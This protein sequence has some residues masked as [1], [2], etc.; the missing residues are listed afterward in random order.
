M[1]AVR[2]N[3]EN[4]MFIRTERL[5]LRPGW[6]EDLDELLELLSDDSVSRTMGASAVP[7]S[8]SELR[9]YIA[10]PHER[11]LPQFFINLRQDGGARVIGSIGLARSG[12]DVELG[13]WIAPAHRGLG[14]AAEAARAVLAQARALGHERVI[15]AHV[16]DHPASGQML[17]HAGFKPTEETRMRR[18]V[19][20]GEA[21]PVRLY[22]AML[23]DKL[24]DL[25]GVQPALGAASRSSQA[26]A[27]SA[28]ISSMRKWSTAMP[29]AG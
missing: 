25:M 7:R 24:Y 21:A 8:V 28:G 16:D 20:R 11:L 23:A 6:P 13:Y 15:A 26:G 18:S 2:G 14:Y 5:F 22:A 12:P 10:R 4:N 9:D 17:E 29:S 3:G 1:L 19:L 27:R